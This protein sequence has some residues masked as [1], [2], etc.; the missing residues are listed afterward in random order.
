MGSEGGRSVVFLDRFPVIPVHLGRVDWVA[1]GR[2][3]GQEK[4]QQFSGAQACHIWWVVL[5]S[6][7]LKIGLG[8]L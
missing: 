7:P 3:E 5:L 8:L 2:S 1:L 4:A 6:L